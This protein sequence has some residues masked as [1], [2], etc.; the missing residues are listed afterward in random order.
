MSTSVP[1]PVVRSVGITQCGISSPLINKVFAVWKVIRTVIIRCQLHP[2]L[3]VLDPAEIRGEQHNVVALH[4][5]ALESHGLI[6]LIN[7][8]VAAPI[9]RGRIRCAVHVLFAHGV[10]I[11]IP[12]LEAFRK[13][14][15][16]RRS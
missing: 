5:A 2:C 7:S 3:V 8:D 16:E 11:K 9:A 1:S 14:L 4:C 12:S 15:S 13:S 6:V 10:G